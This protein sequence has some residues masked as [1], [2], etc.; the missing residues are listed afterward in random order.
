MQDQ[1]DAAMA[2]GVIVYAIGFETDSS[3]SQKLEDCA[4]T[5]SHYYNAEGTQISTVFAAIASSIQKL[6]LTM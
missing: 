5:P 6:K 2:S 3:T 4:S 1:C